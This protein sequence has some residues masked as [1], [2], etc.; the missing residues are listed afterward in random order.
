[1]PKYQ[2][3]SEEIFTVV[4]FLTPPECQ[5]WIAR[6]ESIGFEDAPITTGG[7][8]RMRPDI[9]NNARIMFDDPEQ[10]AELLR[11]A[12][13]YLPQRL[14]GAKLTGVN[15]RLRVY[16]YDVGQQ[17]DWHIDGHFRRDDHER[18]R[19][20]FMVY[21]NDGYEGGE[22]SFDDVAIVPRQGLALCFAHHL[23]H[24][25]EPVVRGRKYVLRTDVMYRDPV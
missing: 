11:Q 24:K 6:A 2:W 23:R 16:R 18:S 14:E 17:F 8:P 12:G 13:D 21:L 25:G 20:T 1:M 7:G 19:L 3:I 22:T 15:E 5:D 10:A 4:K 9:R